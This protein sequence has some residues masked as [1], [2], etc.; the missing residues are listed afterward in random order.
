M[1]IHD[2]AEC[3]IPRTRRVSCLAFS[4]DRRPRNVADD[5][6]ACRRGTRAL[7][8]KQ[9]PPE[10]AGMPGGRHERPADPPA[11]QVLEL[12]SAFA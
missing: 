1:E 8:G 10:S 12:D 5:E 3:R 6:Q 11:S 2:L 4:E 7:G 9:S